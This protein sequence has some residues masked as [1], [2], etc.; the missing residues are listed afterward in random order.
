MKSLET[1]NFCKNRLREIPLELAKSTSI[2]ELFFNDNYLV[3]IP[4]KIMSMKN[5]KV[6]EAESKFYLVFD[7]SF[8]F[9]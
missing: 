9:F 2:T 1:L 4:T 6:F 7:F 8:F 3:E 5:L